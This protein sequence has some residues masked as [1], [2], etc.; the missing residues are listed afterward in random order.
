MILRCKRWHQRMFSVYIGISNKDRR[1]LHPII[2]WSSL[3]FRWLAIDSGY[4]WLSVLPHQ[5]SRQRRTGSYW[6]PEQT[7]FG[8]VI[9][10]TAFQFSAKANYLY[11]LGSLFAQFSV[12][13]RLGTLLRN[14]E[15]NIGECSDVS[16]HFNAIRN[17]RK[18]LWRKC[19]D[20]Y[21]GQNKLVYA[22]LLTLL[23]NVKI[24]ELRCIS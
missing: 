24:M 17:V 12:W 7:N 22:N 23:N 2:R 1:E 14:N 20:T 4:G 15:D 8:A 9:E 5:C 10:N 21:P 19:S 18:V 6:T 16:Q 13:R 3:W 11:S